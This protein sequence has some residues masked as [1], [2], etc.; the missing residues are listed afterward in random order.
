MMSEAEQEETSEQEEV[1][2]SDAHRPSKAAME[3]LLRGL[4]SERLQKL[5][6][7]ADKM[8][9]EESQTFKALKDVDPNFRGDFVNFRLKD[10]TYADLVSE[11]PEPP[12]GFP[13]LEI[14]PVERVVQRD[15]D[16]L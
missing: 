1:R 15:A 16:D 6:H 2:I 11:V 7:M 9:E 8:K 13:F 3:E 4:T 14:E 12:E 5:I 10:I